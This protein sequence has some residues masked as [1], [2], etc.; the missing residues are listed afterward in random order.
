MHEHVFVLSAEAQQNYPEEWDEEVRVADAVSR[1]RALL[2]AG[3]GTIVD[4]TVLGLGRYIPR[5]QRIGELVPE[6]NIVVATGCY[7]WSDV[8]FFFSG[9][10]VEQEALLG[11]PPVDPMIEYF[12][13]DITEGIA[14]TGVRAG[15]L[16]CA[17]HRQG[18]TEGVE[19]VMRAVARVHRRTGV[20]ITVHTY[21]ATR[22]G[23]EVQRLMG[24]EGVDP[25]R[26]ILGHS[27]DSTDPDHLEHL[28]RAGFM[29]GMDRF[30]SYLDS[31]MRSRAAMV[32]E[33]CNRGFASN[34]V[35]SHDTGCYIDWLDPGAMSQR[36][37]WHYLHVVN[38]VLPYLLDEGVSQ[39]QINMMMVENPRRILEPT[40]PY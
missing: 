39:E 24:E 26:V 32:V 8:P 34:M 17:I 9:R 15:M 29:L 1:L 11:R 30:G 14:R 13:R 37:D 16:K 12:T 3:I 21:P 22:Q 36:P 19:R 28:A 31:T 2:N 38:E 27:G 20:P 40:S 7:T 18:M 5:I 25:A 23:L 4:P 33:L 10:T 6:L 35:L